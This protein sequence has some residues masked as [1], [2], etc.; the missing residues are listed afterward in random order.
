MWSF[1]KKLFDTS[2]FP[3]RWHCGNW[4]L[5][6]G[7]IHIISDLAIWAAYMAIPVMLFYFVKKSKGQVPFTYIFLLFCAFIFWCGTVHLIEAT[8][9]WHP[10]YR[11]SGLMKF[12]TA[13]VSVLTAIE[14][15][16]IIPMALSLK[17]PTEL[18]QTVSQ[19]T[20]ELN[21]LSYK[22]KRSNEELEQFAYVASHDLQEPLRMVIQNTRRLQTIFESNL[23]EK[24][25]KYINF[26]I[27]G[28]KRMQQLIED[29]LDYSRFNAENIQFKKVDLNE[30]MQTSLLDLEQKIKE[31]DAIITSD[32]LPIIFGDKV[33]LIRMFE[34][35][36]SNS[37]KYRDNERQLLVTVTAE[38]HESEDAWII[39]FKDN[40][41]GFKQEYAERIFQLFQRLHS[42]SEYPGTGLGLTICK[43]IVSTHNGKIWVDS[44][45]GVGST[46]H[47]WL[48]KL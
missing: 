43:K 24:T 13:V 8:I 38:E 37:I 40:G 27:E 9:F 28:S 2:D 31:S 39:S 20:S 36:I 4:D 18:E 22:L 47:V 45:L 48:P 11:L 25:Q 14:L 19:R 12:I 3:A 46:F 21:E 7:W 34:N 26:T 29:L 16:R 42:K 6:L 30:V 15:F 10:W 23:D 35:L 17:T 41:I 1:F 44:E 32:K 5:F 33:Q